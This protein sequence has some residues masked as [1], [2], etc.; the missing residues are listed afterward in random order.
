MISLGS[1]SAT[2]ST[3]NRWRRLPRRIVSLLMVTGANSY[4]SSTHRVQPFV[5]VAAGEGRVEGDPRR[6]RDGDWRLF[7]RLLGQIGGRDRQ[8]ELACHAV[9]QVAADA[10]DRDTRAAVELD[11][12]AA[13]Q[14]PVDRD[15][16]IRPGILERVARA[17][18]VDA[19]GDAG[20]SS[21]RESDG[22]RSAGECG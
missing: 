18:A 14:Q 12:P 16:R 20:L 17:A 6:P 13:L 9:H 10:R 21:G 5:H 8:A 15:R 2:T 19:A 1:W 4:C 22:G 11:P 3:S 7:V